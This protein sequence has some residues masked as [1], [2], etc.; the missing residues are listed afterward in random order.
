[1]EINKNVESSYSGKEQN[2]VKTYFK[3]EKEN[4][5][6]T[7]S[8]IDILIKNTILDIVYRL[9][10]LLDCN[11]EAK[12]KG[13]NRTYLANMLH[14]APTVITNI[15]S[16][17]CDL[18]IST[19][20]KLLKAINSSYTLELNLV[21]NINSNINIKYK[22][23]VIDTTRESVDIQE[24]FLSKSKRKKKKENTGKTTFNMKSDLEESKTTSIEEKGKEEEENEVENEVEKGSQNKINKNISIT[25]NDSKD[26]KSNIDIRRSRN[27]TTVNIALDMKS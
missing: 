26:I 15:L 21:K 13:M 1:M 24:E 17:K 25:N 27:L 7:I 8:E 19:L 23:G 22:S 18:K 11:L 4:S 12:E 16:G 3:Y 20:I 5:D 2:L 10:H 14:V 6:S 9:N